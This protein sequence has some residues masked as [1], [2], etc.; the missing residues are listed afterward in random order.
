MFCE[1]FGQ[2][3]DMAK[4]FTF[5]AKTATNY[6]DDPDSLQLYQQHFPAGASM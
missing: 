5:S 3:C 6:F 2:L 4:G 1:Q